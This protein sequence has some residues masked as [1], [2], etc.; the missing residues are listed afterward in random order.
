MEFYVRKG[1][2]PELIVVFSPV[3]IPTVS[4]DFLDI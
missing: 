4:L 3:N 1:S 2:L